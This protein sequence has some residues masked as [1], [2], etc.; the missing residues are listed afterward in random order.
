MDFNIGLSGLDVAQEA[1]AVIS[2]NIANAAS[3]GYHRQVPMIEPL[4]F[5][6][7]AGARIGG[8][9]IQRIVRYMDI[10]M[11]KELLRQQPEH[12]EVT[13]ELVALETLESAFGDVD[14]ENLAAAMSRFFSSLQELAGQ[15]D[16]R[17]LR[18]QTIWAADGLSAQFHSVATFLEG[19]SENIRLKAELV[20]EEV[21]GFVE[22]IASLNNEIQGMELKGSDTN[23]LR[24][25]R[26]QAIMDLAE[27][28]PLSLENTN[29]T[30]SM[31]DVVAWGTPLV[32]GSIPTRLE[33]AAVSGGALA[34]SIEGDNYYVSTY[35]GG[36]LGA[37]L[38][39][40]NDILPQIQ[41]DIDVMA[42]EIIWL[43]NRAHAQGVGTHGSFTDLEGTG[44]ASAVLEDWDWP[45]VSGD[46]RIRLID[47][48]GGVTTHTVTVDAT[49]DTLASVAGKIAALDPANLTATATA[50]TIHVQGL[51]GH[52]FDF[53]PMTTVDASGLLDPDAPTVTA[54][55]IY[56]GTQNQTYTATVSVD[57]G[58]SG[59]VGITDGVSLIVRDGG[60]DIVK[61]LTIGDGYASGDLLS[62]DEGIKIALGPGTVNDGEVIT[63][64]ALENSDET[65]FLAATGLNAL[66][67][68]NSSG[69]ICV[70]EEILEDP[71]LLATAV[72]PAMNDNVAALRMA[73]V[74]E[75]KSAA[76]GDAT[77]ADAYR[78]LASSMGEKIVV[79][80]ARQS[81]VESIQ[82]QLTN[83]RDAV[84]GV[85]INEEAAR[86]ILFQRMFQSMAKVISTQQRSL[87]T[88]MTVI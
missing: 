4:E 12:G 51:S 8:A 24:D 44:P 2:T 39:L 69:T 21:N 63:L 53:L 28:V 45:V 3:D 38:G 50:S 30:E 59:Q 20:V 46:F 77:P 7:V 19:L 25:R 74:N 57:G 52:V 83:Q 64:E 73:E 5:R 88:L 60:G 76:L 61:V 86:L 22:Q 58:G 34:L 29:L 56:Q 72:S 17:A 18:E 9:R 26:D 49:T 37:L 80:R 23:L 75:T 68:G 1:M 70:R 71:R 84:S 16:S 87:E 55:G 14:T 13:E 36:K 47:A 67:L 11:E 27:L 48:S 65:G 33:I 42:K 79:R 78:I 10:L 32:T 35:R 31:A 40:R 43:I 15:P 62:V 82:Q 41:D 85:D 81:A 66:F 6:S 54:E